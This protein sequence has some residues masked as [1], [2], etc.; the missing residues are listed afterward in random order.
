MMSKYSGVSFQKKSQKWRAYRVINR[1]Q[2]HL[3]LFNSEEKAYKAVVSF[4]KKRNIPI[5]Q[6]RQKGNYYKVDENGITI[7]QE[8]NQCREW[9][10]REHFANSSATKSGLHTWCRH[11]DRLKK[12]GWTRERYERCYEAQKGKCFVANCNNPIEVADHCHETNTPRVLFCKR[13]NKAE[14]AFSNDPEALE[15]LISYMK[16]WEEEAALAHNRCCASALWELL[17]F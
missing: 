15:G 12:T 16:Y 6:A 7:E 17:P 5:S 1:K 3:G 9:L 2:Y 14:G 11:C 10:S 8:C 4:C 13:C